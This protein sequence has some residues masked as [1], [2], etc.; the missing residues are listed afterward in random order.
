MMDNQK[1]LMMMM[2]TQ[3]SEQEIKL[4]GPNF[5]GLV[6]LAADKVTSAG[7][8]GLSL[9]GLDGLSSLLGLR[10]ET[11]ILLSTSKEICTALGVAQMLNADVHTLLHNTVLNS[12]VENNP[13]CAARNVEN[14]TSLAV[15]A[16]VRHAKLNCTIALNIHKI[17][18]FVVLQVN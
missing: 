16:L 7:L 11:I 10:L 13:Q 2:V 6:T 4:D 15:V 12:L 14:P 9:R 8:L 17:T 5:L 18:N 3:R 1:T